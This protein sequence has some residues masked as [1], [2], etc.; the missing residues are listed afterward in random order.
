M[1]L[2][3]A[4]LQTDIEDGA[5]QAS[6]KVFSVGSRVVTFALKSDATLA[7]HLVIDPSVDDAVVTGDHRILSNTIAEFISNPAKYGAPDGPIIISATLLS[8]RGDVRLWVTNLADETQI[9]VTFDPFKSF[10]QADQSLERTQEG[11]GIGL[12]YVRVVAHLHAGEASLEQNDETGLITAVI[13]L[14]NADSPGLR[15]STEI[16]NDA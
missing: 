12:T 7:S 6:P 9:Q 15:R 5:V 2:A 8:E 1:A 3:T 4:A 13:N 10:G 16:M 11:L 14:P